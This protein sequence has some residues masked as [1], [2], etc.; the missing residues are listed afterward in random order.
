MSDSLVKLNAWGGLQMKRFVLFLFVMA[1]LCLGVW[2]YLDESHGSHIGPVLVISLPGSRASS[3]PVSVSLDAT[4]TGTSILGRP[5]LSASFIDGVLARVQSP[6]QGTG[7]VFYQESV[8]TGIDDAYPFGIFQHESSFG[9]AGA[10]VATHNPGNIVCAGYPTCL[11]RFR[12][13]ATWAAGVRD[14]YALLAREY[15][16]H[17]LQTLESILQVYAPASDGNAPLDY[18]AAVKSSIALWRREMARSEVS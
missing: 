9:L 7:Q 16:P 10:A 8:Q 4:S 17:H 18:I 3:A 5:S 15:V 14:L 11:G 2:M 1:L 13:Y 12:S 6:A